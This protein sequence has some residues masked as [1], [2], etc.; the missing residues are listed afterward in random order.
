MSLVVARRETHQF[1]I[2]R[3]PDDPGDAGNDS[4]NARKF[5]GPRRRFW[6]DVEIH[7]RRCDRRSG[8]ILRLSDPYPRPPQPTRDQS[9]VRE[10]NALASSPARRHFLR[11]C[12]LQLSDE[13][14][15]RHT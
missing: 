3:H 10:S 13:F 9:V 2:G 1:G 12:G 14:P 8:G 4:G 6:H 5:Q 15:V 7:G 11:E